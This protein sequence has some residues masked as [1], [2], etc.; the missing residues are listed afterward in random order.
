MAGAA[1]MDSFVGQ[2]WLGQGCEP[3]SVSPLALDYIAR[4]DPELDSPVLTARHQQVAN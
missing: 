1:A 3:A 4:K 2:V